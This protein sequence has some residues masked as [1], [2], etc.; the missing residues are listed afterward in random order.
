MPRLNR[1]SKRR[2]S[3]DDAGVVEHLLTG[4]CLD[5]LILIVDH[6]GDALRPEWEKLRDVLLPQFVREH[7]GTRP[8]AWWAFDAPGHVAHRWTRSS[9][10]SHRRKLHVAKSDSKRFWEAAYRLTWGYPASFIVP[11]D[12]GIKAAMFEQ[13][14]EYLVRHNL[15]LPEDT[16]FDTE[17]AK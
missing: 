2:S 12:A 10:R 6:D 14:W 3:G 1:K 13:D 5:C 17:A 7:P 8:W 16:P 11:F 15:L 4:S 9:V